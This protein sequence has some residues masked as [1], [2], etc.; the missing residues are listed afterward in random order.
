MINEMKTAAIV[1]SRSDSTRLPK[2]AFLPL[3][4]ISLISHVLLRSCK[5]NVDQIILATTNRSC[6]DEYEQL[7]KS[8]ELKGVKNINIFRGSCDNVVKRTIDALAANQI[9]RFC[10]IN[11][12]C[13][14]FP[15][16]HINNFI[17]NKKFSFINN[18]RYRSF[19]Y[20]ISIE[21]LDTEFYLNNSKNVK[22]EYQE[23]V[24]QHLYKHDKF[25]NE[26]CLF[27]NE[28]NQ[29][30]FETTRSYV[31]DT[32]DDYNFWSKKV[33]TDSLKPD[34]ILL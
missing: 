4:Q 19:P 29:E 30:Y 28:I 12:D 26:K 2:K 6:D 33:K 1:Y 18:I 17:D 22:K 24:T 3:G 15:Y 34:T 25:L 16:N 27:L 5:L 20:G 14:F 9:D 11:G 21:I 31:I 8:D 7:L 13:P 23:H 32:V 10:R